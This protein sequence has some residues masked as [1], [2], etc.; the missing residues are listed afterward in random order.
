MEEA[1]PFGAAGRR[2]GNWTG[3]TRRALSVGTRG[4]T[5]ASTFFIG[6]RACGSY[7]SPTRAYN[8]YSSGGSSATRSSGHG[9]GPS[10]YGPTR[11]SGSYTLRRADES[12]GRG[13]LCGTKRAPRS[14]GGAASWSREGWLTLTCTSTRRAFKAGRPVGTPARSYRPGGLTSNYAPGHAYALPSTADRR[15]SIFI[16]AGRS[17]RVAGLDRACGAL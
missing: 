1:F 16:G 2:G 13:P 10:T 17:A 11:W 15:C 12:S 14:P 7:R 3:G 8:G 4:S 5:T 6:R 9:A